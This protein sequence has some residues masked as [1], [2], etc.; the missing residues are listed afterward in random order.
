M[1][2]IAS[3][4]FISP[5]LQVEIGK[6]PPAFLPLGNRRLYEHQI[7]VLKRTFPNEAIYLSVNESYQLKNSDELS[8]AKLGVSLVRVPDGLTLGN[9]I[10]Y[11]INTIGKY[12][13]TLRILHG[14]TFLSEI[15]F[16]ED[17]IALAEPEDQYVWEIESEQDQ[18]VWC[19]FFAFSNIK[20]LARSL[21]VT[22]GNFVDAIRMYQGSIKVKCVLVYGWLDMGHVN[23][24]F[25]SR[26]NMTTQRSFNEL[27]I[28][29]GVVLKSSLQTR[30][31]EAE[32]NWFETLPNNLKHYIPQFI[33]NGTE[34][35]VSFYEVEY[36]PN[37][38]LNELFVHGNLPLLFW[39]R[40]FKIA[41]KV[42]NDFRNSKSLT[43]KEKE[44]VSSD[45][46]KIINDKTLERLSEFELQEGCDFNKETSLNGKELPSFY[47]IVAECQQ[48]ATALEELPGISHGDFCFSNLLYDSR[49]NNLKLIDPRGMNFSQ[50]FIIIGDLKYDIAK[51][52]HSVIGFYDHIVAGLFTVKEI[53]GMHFFFEVHTDQTVRMI[54]QEFMS[55]FSLLGIKTND[56][57]PVVILLFLSMPPLHNED[58]NRQLAFLANSLRLYA[59]WKGV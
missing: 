50:E 5:E 51:F 58:A 37:L 40:I 27:K 4:A 25:R 52:A 54:E 30:K 42:L 16:D 45:F 17:L 29:G 48:A 39:K 41:E 43:I 8:I 12:N 57:L 1:I 28:S 2:L 14:D 56:V 34:R 11:V 13:E 22:N 31:I 18:K 36:L 49:L 23:T 9:S 20:S 47:Q 32:A 35:N 38:P 15:P 53:E 26:A 24:F 10:L 3:A 46:N 7:D 55:N 44:I 19:G 21:A 59:S 6:V 33:R